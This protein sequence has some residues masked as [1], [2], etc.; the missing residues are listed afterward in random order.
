MIFKHLVWPQAWPFQELCKISPM[1]FSFFL[2]PF[3]VGEP[4]VA[5]G[6]EGKVTAIQIFFTVLTTFNNRTIII[7]NT[8]LSNEVIVNLSWKGKEE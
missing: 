4:I 8:K 5:Q 2:K 1:V 3:R 7:P 6:Q